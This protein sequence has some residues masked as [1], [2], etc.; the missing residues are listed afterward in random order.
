MSKQQLQI[1]QGMTL[2]TLLAVLRRYR[3]QVEPPY[4]HRLIHLGLLA[5]INSLLAL[6]ERSANRRLI[7]ASSFPR[8]PIIIIGHWRSGTTHL[9]NLLNQDPRFCVPTLYQTMFPHHFVYSQR[10]GKKLMAKLVPATRPMDRM[11]LSATTPHEDEFA[12]AALSGLSVYF[13]F[14]FPTTGQLDQDPLDH[15]SLPPDLARRWESAFLAFLKSVATKNSRA[16]RIVLKSP[17]HTGRI[18]TLL[19]LQPGCKFVHMVRDPYAVF[20]S[21]RHLWRAGL[22]HSHLQTLDQARLDQHI[23]LFYQQFF[24][25]FERDRLKIPPGSLCQIRHEQLERD[26][27]GCLERVYH[28]LG[29]GRFQQARPAF[30][31]YLASQANYRKNSYCLSLAE[32]QLVRRHWLAAFEAYGYPQDP[33]ADSEYLIT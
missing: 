21:T 32:Q 30:E 31:Q 8:P 22:A 12:L 15:E 33:P 7:Q 6:V 18:P 19:R 4:R 17:P 29:L 2:S 10:R 11:A 16:E 20:L 25:I 28:D 26:P 24:H 5:A 23:I 14:L 1:I 9:H 3:F 27:L 13:Q